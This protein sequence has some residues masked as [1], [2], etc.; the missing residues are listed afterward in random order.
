MSAFIV[1]EGKEDEEF[2]NSY[3][4]FLGLFDSVYSLRGINGKD[5]LAGFRNELSPKR[6][7]REGC[8]K[9]L[10]IF[11]A[12]SN[13]I[14]TVNIIEQNLASISPDGIF[15]FPDNE[16]EG[17]LEDLLEKIV[18]PEYENIFECFE[19]YKECLSAKNSTY[20]HPDLKGK[21]FAYMDALEK[22][23]EQWFKQEYWDFDSSHLE[24]LKGF[25]EKHLG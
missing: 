17:M 9:V 19:Q 24:P 6:L 16:S 18:R 8:S 2:L 15:L 3:I 14:E 21:V 10:I 7:K 13:C 22:N 5:N 23:R 25:L 20:R 11:D 12:D 4:R 1:V